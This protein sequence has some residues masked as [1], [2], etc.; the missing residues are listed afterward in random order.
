[1][2]GGVETVTC[3]LKNYKFI[4]SSFVFAH[5]SVSTIFERF[6]ADPFAT[7]FEFICVTIIV[8]NCL[9]AEAQLFGTANIF[10]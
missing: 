1:M 8:S 9:D 5:W 7:E 4:K 2:A 6:L 10:F 3:R